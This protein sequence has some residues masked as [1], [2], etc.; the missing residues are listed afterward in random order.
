MSEDT[1]FIEKYYDSPSINE[2]LKCIYDLCITIK[3]VSSKKYYS[4]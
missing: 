3:D 1:L 4:N 2:L